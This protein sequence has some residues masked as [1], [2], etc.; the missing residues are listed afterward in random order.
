MNQMI[1]TVSQDRL[2]SQIVAKAWSDEDFKQR[3][4]TDP[5]SVFTEYGL[6]LPEGV[7]LM[8]HNNSP[9]IQHFILPECPDGDLREEE[10]TGAGM[11]ADSFSGFSGACG[12][13]GRCGCGCGRCD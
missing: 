10:V 2:W 11:S 8:V 4:L 1:Q 12:R 3:L 7:E 6:E 5:R 13:C 9:M